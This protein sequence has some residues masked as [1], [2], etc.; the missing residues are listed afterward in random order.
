MSRVKRA[1]HASD[2]A[3]ALPDLSR[4]RFLQATGL[5]SLAGMSGPLLAGCG[6]EASGD[7]KSL[8]FVAWGGTQEKNTIK[9]LF[10]PWAHKNKVTMQSDSPTNYAKFRTQVKSGQVSW[11][12]VQVEPFFATQACNNGWATKLDFDTIDA[13]AVEDKF[14]IDCAVPILQYAFTIAYNTKKYSKDDH[15]TTWEEFFDTKRFPGKR[16]FWKYA[17]S[18]TFEAALLADGVDA[19]D[20]YPLDVDRALQKLD[21]IRDDIVW[22][23]TG[24]EQVQLLASGEAPLVQAWNG[25]V[26]Q[27]S[28]QGRPVANEW[29]EHFLS[30][31]QLL[32][33]KGYE[34]ASLAQKWMNWFLNAPKAQARFAETTAYAAPNP[35][36]MDHVDEA[37]ARELPTYPANK[38]KRAAV[39]DYPYYAEHYDELTK[40]LN[41]WIA[42]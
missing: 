42:G 28:Q 32:I 26:F 2:P 25:R 4:R 1:A 14:V 10:K 29:N 22:Y 13:S 9:T 16:A 23:E 21:T 6:G 18:T 34:Y 24:E 37:V 20:L 15:P 8:T 17:T 41:A 38:K 33:P 27:A 7:P 12:I 35:K 30:Y 5:A 31:E 19:S 3:A 40:K 36:F 39:V 11:S